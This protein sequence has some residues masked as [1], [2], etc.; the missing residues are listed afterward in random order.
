MRRDNGPPAPKDT[1]LYGLLKIEREKEINL[2]TMDVSAI[3]CHASCLLKPASH[4]LALHLGTVKRLN[5]PRSITCPSPVLFRFMLSSYC[6]K[7]ISISISTQCLRISPRRPHS[8][9]AIPDP[10]ARKAGQFCCSVQLL[11]CVMRF[12][13]VGPQAFKPA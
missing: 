13:Y 2:I 7:S 10:E 9:C 6:N 5:S 12:K 3:L 11:G 4:I 8:R 1:S